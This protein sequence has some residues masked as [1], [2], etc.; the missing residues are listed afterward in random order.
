M[1]LLN[2]VTG[3]METYDMVAKEKIDLLKKKIDE[4]DA[5]VVGGASG[6]SAAS[7]FV[8][9]YQ[10]DDVY[11]ML[12]GG[13]AEKYNIHNY[14]DLFYDRRLSRGEL[15]ASM[16]RATRYIYECYT[17]ETY[18]DLAKLLQGKN[19]YIATTPIRMHSFSGYSRM[20]RLLGFK[21]ITV[22]GNAAVRVTMKYIIIRRKF[23]S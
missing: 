8:F 12:A 10:D 15:W 22:T 17:G 13:L 7:G 1:I 19:Y 20:K 16:L 3:K 23:S 5:I 6:M 4:A 9:Y 11:K 18:K 21:E 14:F 2:F